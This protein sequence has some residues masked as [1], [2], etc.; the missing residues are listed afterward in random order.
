LRRSR[1]ESVAVTATRV[2]LDLYW[3]TDVVGGLRLGWVWFATCSP[4]FGGRLR[5]S[6]D[7]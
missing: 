7:D 5:F 4:A 2:L 3:L 6:A 1:R